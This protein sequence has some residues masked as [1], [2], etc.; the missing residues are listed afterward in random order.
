[1]KDVTLTR[2]EL[3]NLVWSEP[4]STILKKYFNRCRI[5]KNLCQHGDTITKVWALAK[6]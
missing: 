5:Q 2:E 1:M 4:V 6:N 3:Y